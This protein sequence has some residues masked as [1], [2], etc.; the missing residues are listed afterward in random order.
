MKLLIGANF[1]AFKRN[2]LQ[3]VA[4]GFAVQMLVQ[5]YITSDAMR[6]LCTVGCYLVDKSVFLCRSVHDTGVVSDVVVSL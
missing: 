3:D 4:D 6:L 2:I 5:V 1:G